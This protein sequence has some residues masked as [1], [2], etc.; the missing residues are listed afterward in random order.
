VKI[1]ERA[2]RGGKTWEIVQRVSNDPT[3]T[4]ICPNRHMVDHLRYEYP[5][6]RCRVL[7]WD[8]RHQMKD[9]TPG[10]V[11]IDN[12]DLIVAAEVRASEEIVVTTSPAYAG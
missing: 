4:I 3:A 11:A 7:P 10:P 1:I 6:L 8:R 9:Y 2:R 5:N 12:L